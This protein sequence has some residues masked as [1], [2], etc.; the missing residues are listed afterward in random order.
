ME[1]WH[2]FFAAEVGATAALAGLLFVALSINRTQILKYDWLPACG[3]QTLVVLTGALLEASLALFP[4]THFTAVAGASIT[5]A[6]VTWLS[7]LLL[8][9]A[10]VR[11]AGRQKEVALPRDRGLKYVVMAQIATLPAI[12]GSGLLFSNNADGY[13]WIAGGLLAAPTYAL[14]NAWILLIE[15]LR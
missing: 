1:N 4:G 10:F 7:S 6:V 9:I 11:G 12:A 2:D 13:Y 8:A 15:I 14:Y 5:V 3:A